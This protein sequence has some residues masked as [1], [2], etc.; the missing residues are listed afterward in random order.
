MFVKRYSRHFGRTPGTSGLTS[1][2]GIIS[3]AVQV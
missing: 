1:R 3:L 2:T